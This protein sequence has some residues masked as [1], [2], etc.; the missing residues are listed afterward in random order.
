MVSSS[1]HFGFVVI[2]NAVKDLQFR[3]CGKMQIPRRCAPRNDNVS[4]FCASRGYVA[5]SFQGGTGCI[6]PNF[7]M[8]R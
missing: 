5:P 3:A 7:D 8:P 4:D 6:A 2:L 1:I